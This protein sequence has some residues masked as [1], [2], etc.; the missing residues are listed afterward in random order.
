MEKLTVRKCHFQ[1]WFVLPISFLLSLILLYFDNTALNGWHQNNVTFLVNS[2]ANPAICQAPTLKSFDSTG[3]LT[4]S[5]STTP[6]TKQ[7]KSSLDLCSGRYIYMHDLPSQFNDDLLKNCSSIYQWHDMCPYVSNMGLGPRVENDPETVL[8][9]KG[10]FATNQFTLEII[11]H[12]RMKHYECL[13]KDSSLASAIYVPFYAGLDVGQFLWDFNE[14]MRDASSFRLLKWLSQKPEW[15]RMYG[16]DHFLVAG[17]IAWDFRRHAAID[18]PGWGSQ[19][20]FLPESKN[21]TLLSIES[22]LWNNDF[23]IP[24][25]THFHPSQ[26]SQV[27]LKYKLNN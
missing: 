6:V 14:S 25:P 24:Y 23:S 5:N 9:K 8:L 26:Y 20:M 21:M 7:P 19:L 15:E 22:C 3:T 2:F 4:S 12:N 16:R 13:T 1:L 11:F 17:R 18:N 27:M 10:W